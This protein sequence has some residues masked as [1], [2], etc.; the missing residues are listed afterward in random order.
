M[1]AKTQI[2]AFVSRETK[3]RLDRFVRGRGVSQ[4]YVIEQALLHHLAAL[5]ELP[6]EALVPA[7][8]VLTAASGARVVARIARKP[9]PNRA[10]RELF[11]GD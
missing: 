2:S 5:A 6:A 10:M 1:T 7:R 11:D 3:S 4:A 9:R 8:V